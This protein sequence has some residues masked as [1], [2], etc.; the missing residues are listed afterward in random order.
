MNNQF[1]TNPDSENFVSSAKEDMTSLMKQQ[2]N[3]TAS[4]N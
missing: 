1:G 3:N 4:L 2:D